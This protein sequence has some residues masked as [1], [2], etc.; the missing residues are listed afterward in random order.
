MITDEEIESMLAK[1]IERDVEMFYKA[2][3]IYQCKL[4]I[5][6]MCQ[7]YEYTPPLVK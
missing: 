2:V 4:F 5:D 3:L 1:W 6:R 7:F